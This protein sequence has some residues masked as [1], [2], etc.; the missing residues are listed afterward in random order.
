M[1]L[2]DY[3][4]YLQEDDNEKA[5]EEKAAMIKTIAKFI[6][7]P[8]GKAKLANTLSPVNKA[9]LLK[10]IKKK[11]RIAAGVGLAGVGTAGFATSKRAD[12]KGQSL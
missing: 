3:L 12:K 5:V 10:L 6:K 4:N 8:Y 2:D 1:T 9:K 7:D 11:K